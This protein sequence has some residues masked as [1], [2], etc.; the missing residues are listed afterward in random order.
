MFAKEGE[1]LQSSQMWES[2][3]R[4]AKLSFFVKLAECFNLHN[5][6][7]HLQKEKM[8]NISRDCYLT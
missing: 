4:E 3:S 8:G 2:L 5:L 7:M 6:R 1:K